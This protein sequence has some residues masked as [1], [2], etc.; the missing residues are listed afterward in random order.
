M[1]NKALIQV[2]AYVVLLAIAFIAIMWCNNLRKAN[3]TLNVEINNLRNRYNALQ[4]DYTAYQFAM[5]KKEETYA[6]TQQ[7]LAEINTADASTIAD[8]LQ[9]RPKK[10][11]RNKDSSADVPIS[12]TATTK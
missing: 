4:Q 10:S 7:K 12:S 1:L 3:K 8:K 5:Q 2:L 11:V 6:Q 9:H